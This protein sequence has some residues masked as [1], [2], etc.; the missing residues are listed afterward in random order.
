MFY[1]LHSPSD[2]S[3]I[4][5]VLS[6][7][8]NIDIVALIYV[9][10]ACIMV[11]NINLSFAARNLSPRGCPKVYIKV[12]PALKNHGELLP[13]SSSVLFSATSHIECND[14]TIV[15]YEIPL[16]FH[17]LTDTALSASRL[18]LYCLLV[19]CLE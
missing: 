12:S 13:A 15:N 10:C 19:T 1:Q 11:L 8:I 17:I 4:V 3:R 7:F 5:P 9:F 14:Q 16:W 2:V 18:C 6:I